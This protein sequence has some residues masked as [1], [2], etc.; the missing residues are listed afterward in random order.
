MYRFKQL[1]LMFGDLLAL[2]F[3][4][5]LAIV[6]RYFSLSY[7]SYNFAKLLPHF[8]PLFLVAVVTLYIAGV[9]DLS[10]IKNRRQF[11][12]K[13]A[14]AALSWL[15]IGVLYFY[16]KKTIFISPKT[17]LALATVC[18]F[19]LVALWRFIHNKFIAHNILSSGVVFVGLTQEAKELINFIQ[20]NTGC[21]YKLIGIIEKNYQSTNYNGGIVSNSLSSL[22]NAVSKK[23]INLIVMAPNLANKEEII[24]ELYSLIFRQMNIVELENFY[25]E[26]LGRI[27]PFTFSQGWFL[28]NLREQQKKI[29][30]RLKIIID[31]LVAL[32]LS[33]FFAITFPLIATTIKINSRGPIFFKQNRVG[34]KNKEFTMIKYR[35]MQVLNKDGSAE[36][37]GPQFAQKQDKRLTA[38]GKFLRATRLD[39]VPQFIN[40]LRGEMGLI[41]PRPERPEFVREL[42][43][44]MPYYA[45]RHIIKPGL[46][47]WAQLQKDYY[48]TI[49]ENLRKLE[50]DLFYIKHRSFFLDLIIMLRT[51]NILLGFKGR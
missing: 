33:I 45:L 19:S 12:Q 24:K 22:N 39:E 40:I 14:L 30:D 7:A 16:L 28:F 2:Y 3:G 31:Y 15:F 43:E 44:K 34:R 25:E 11:Y 27:P 37:A 36:T 9:Y 18:G 49:E 17:I 51:I 41:G 46:T 29:Y 26:L 48:G 1:I 8:Y 23:E 5:Y 13:I 21:G 47:G 38:V 35:T 10:Q 32:L 6:L 50:Y 42:T 4:L 20:R